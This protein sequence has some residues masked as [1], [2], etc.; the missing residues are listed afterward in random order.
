MRDI[1]ETRCGNESITIRPLNEYGHDREINLNGF[2]VVR[3][4]F[5]RDDLQGALSLA[6]K[7]RENPSYYCSKEPN[8]PVVRSILGFERDPMVQE[9]LSDTRF[10]DAAKTAVGGPCYIHQSR[11]NYKSGM[12]SNGWKWHSDFETWHYQ[13]GMPGMKCVSAMIPLDENTYANGALMVLRGSHKYFVS[14]AEPTQIASAEENFSD[15][16]EGI[17]SANAIHHMMDLGCEIVT[18]ECDPG[19]LVLFDCNTLHVSNP[20]VTPFYRTNMFFVFNNVENKIVAPFSGQAPRPDEMGRR[21][22]LLTFM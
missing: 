22:N 13:D 2:K 20:N 3:G 1:Y 15:Q 19:D 8:S 16:V 6:T 5:R 4:F 11:I 9:I 7:N 10:R 17:P 21:E 18:L 12:Q 14:T